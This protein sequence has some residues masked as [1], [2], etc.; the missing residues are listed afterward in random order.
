MKI[1]N[2]KID[3]HHKFKEYASKL[4]LSNDLRAL[5]KTV[6]NLVD[7][8][9]DYQ[10]MVLYYFTPHS[11]KLRAVTSKGLTTEERFYAQKTA[12]ERAPGRCLRLKQ[13]IYIKDA[14]EEA[15]FLAD[16]FSTH[17][18]LRSR[19]Y[20]PLIYENHVL[21]VYSIA[22]T[23]KEHFSEDA[24]ELISYITNIAAVIYKKIV[25]TRDLLRINKRLEEINHNFLSQKLQS[26]GQLAAGIAHELNTPLQYINDNLQFLANSYQSITMFMQSLKYLL[27]EEENISIDEFKKVVKKNIIETDLNFFLSEIPAAISQS[28]EGIEKLNKIIKTIR[29]FSQVGIREKFFANINKCI[30]DTVLISRNEWKNIADVRLNLHPDLPLVYCQ[31]DEINQVLLHLLLNA[32]D[33]I[34]EK[35]Q[36]DQSYKFGIIEISTCFDSNGI[37]VQ[38]RDNGIGIQEKHLDKI[39]DPFFT[40]KSPGKGT[41]QGLAIAHNVIC[42][43]HSGDIFVSSNYLK[44]TEFIIKLPFS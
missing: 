16:K 42:S 13:I 30:E 10:Y 7:E 35:M 6:D 18:L 20:I 34:K 39:F 23:E 43:K 3:Y 41:G 44:G 31:V 33:A 29:D 40:T 15:Y 12:L 5:F 17:T 21:G 1:S 9:I 14:D 38:I 24:I 25:D 8:V 37:V 11:G 26:I 28:Q 22:S 32:I 19:L 2:S 27:E 36:I 4:V